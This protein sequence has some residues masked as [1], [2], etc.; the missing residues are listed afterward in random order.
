MTTSQL[1]TGC[2]AR[3]QSQHLFHFHICA[4]SLRSVAIILL[5]SITLS[6]SAFILAVRAGAVILNNAA[7][8]ANPFTNY[9][10]MMP[11]GS[12]AVLDEYRCQ[13][14]FDRNSTPPCSIMPADGPF[15][16]IN[17]TTRNGGITEVNFFSES[18]QLVDLIHQWGEPD[19]LHRSESGQ[20]TML[21]WNM[22]TQQILA[23]LPL[24]RTQPHV[25]LVT[26]RLSCDNTN[27]F[28]CSHPT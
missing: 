2:V 17:A 9:D 18:L 26:V 16:L 8:P 19:S 23:T 1:Q 10:S 22:G 12:E 3:V 25:R 4:D 7:N 14:P 24:Y 5:A 6:F 11:G 15:H 27:G 20:A 21:V 28:R 13:R